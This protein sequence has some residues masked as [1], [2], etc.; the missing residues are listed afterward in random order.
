MTTPTRY[1]A[2]CTACGIV[3]SGLTVG[4][5]ARRTKNDPQRGGAVYTSGMGSIVLD[6][7]GCGQYRR[8]FP[9]RGRF[10]AKHECSAKCMSSTGTTC[11][12]SC[13]G[14]NH[15]DQHSA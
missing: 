1:L 4:Q 15:G 9:V 14:K 13:S 6:C 7:R 5:D 10:S 12:C 3:T 8:A 2:K 11:E